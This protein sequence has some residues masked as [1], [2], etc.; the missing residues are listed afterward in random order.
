MPY[1]PKRNTTCIP[2]TR[3]KPKAIT[4]GIIIVLLGSL[5]YA[6]VL[7][8]P[9]EYQVKAV[10]LF[11]FSKFTRWPTSAFSSSQAPIRICVLGKNPFDDFGVLVKNKIVKGRKVTVAQLHDFRKANRCHIL[12]VS[13]SEQGDQA[14]ILAYTQQY[15]ILTVSDIKNF[16][17]RG[18]MIQFYIRG[19]K[20]RFMV[21]PDTLKEAG[22]SASANLLRVAKIV[23]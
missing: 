19:R 23:K 20:V 17:V 2:K 16:V 10:Y 12:F 18:G 5:T 3:W 6:A 13:K 14:A 4:L 11:N 7:L 1:Q 21:D 8:T 15:P 9:K 22:L